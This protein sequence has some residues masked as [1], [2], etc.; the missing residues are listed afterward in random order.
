MTLSLCTTFLRSLFLSLSWPDKLF[1]SDSYNEQREERPQ[2]RSAGLAFRSNHLEPFL[3][4]GL[5]WELDFRPN[6]K[7]FCLSQVPNGDVQQ[8]K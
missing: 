5:P 6:F 3:I 7:A 8:R 2:G 4:A 1:C